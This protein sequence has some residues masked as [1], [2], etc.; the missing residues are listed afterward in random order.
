MYASPVVAAALPRRLDARRG[1][2]DD[3]RSAWRDAVCP[4]ERDDARL[5]AALRAERP[6][7]FGEFVTDYEN[8]VYSLALRLVRDREDARDLTQDVVL[9][10]YRRIPRIEGELHLWAWL[11]RV[12]VNACRD[13]LRAA[14]RRPLLV[15]EAEEPA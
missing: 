9:K 1:G 8:A 13:H 7:A 6:G 4:A 12:T 14:K 11:H 2:R 10:A 15:N 3:A 5:V